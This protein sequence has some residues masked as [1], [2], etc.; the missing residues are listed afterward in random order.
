MT[1]PTAPA[2]MSTGLDVDGIGVTV[3]GSPEFVGRVLAE[4]AVYAARPGG[5]SAVRITLRGTAGRG[6][7][8]PTGSIVQR[9]IRQYVWY[10]DPGGACWVRMPGS[11]WKV[12]RGPGQVHA[13]GTG[14]TD[15]LAEVARVL[16][17]AEVAAAMESRGCLA[18]HGAAVERAGRAVLLLG[19]SGYGKSTLAR[20]LGGVHGSTVVADETCF[21]DAGDG[22][23]RGYLPHTAAY[24]RQHPGLIVTYSDGVVRTLTPAAAVA[25]PYPVDAVVIIQPF[26]AR[27]SVLRPIS[28]QAAFRYLAASA[29]GGVKAD[30]RPPD[31]AARIADRLHRMGALLQRSRCYAMLASRDPAEV[32][33]SCASVLAVAEPAATSRTV[34]R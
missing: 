31:P 17:E 28:W 9:R 2:G 24:G 27:A 22:M 11:L 18:L 34:R 8:L 19:Q 4:H 16:L 7:E 1:E 13:R 33:A 26:Q 5:G 10:A 20:N 14:S 21:F 23:L 30:F 32:A 12:V 3:T 29:A 25:P 15:G 6:A